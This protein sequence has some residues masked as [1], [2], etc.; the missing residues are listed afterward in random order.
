MHVKP[1]KNQ[2]NS[3]GISLY[4]KK[5]VVSIPRMRVLKEKHF[6]GSIHFVLFPHS[7]N[8]ELRIKIQ[9]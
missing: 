7:Q 6:N 2:Y 4:G 1:E 8:N 9:L 5:F 3:Y